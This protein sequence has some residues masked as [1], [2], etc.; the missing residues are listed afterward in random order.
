[1]LLFI[2]F[3]EFAKNSEIKIDLAASL[4]DKFR[5]EQFSDNITIHFLD[6]GKR[7]NFKTLKCSYLV[8]ELWIRNE[9]FKIKFL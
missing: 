3:K 9:K 5:I 4:I 6:I 7:V 2:Y 1:M 8:Y